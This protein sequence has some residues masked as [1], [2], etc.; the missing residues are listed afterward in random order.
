MQNCRTFLDLYYHIKEFGTMVSP[1]GCKCL[2]LTN[3]CVT[4]NSLYPVSSFEARK[5]NLD[6]AKKETLWYLRGDRF[7]TSICQE[8]GAWN[9]LVQPDGGINSN[10]GQDIFQGPKLFDWVIEE[11]TR[12]KMSRRAVMPLGRADMLGADNSDHR[13][14]MFISYLIRDN[15]LIQSVHMRSNDAIFGLTNDVFFFGLLHQMVLVCL[16]EVYP[17]LELGEYHHIVDSIHVYER[18]FSMLDRLLSENDEG[19][20]DLAIPTFKSK[21]EVDWLRGDR[22]TS[23]DSEMCNWLVEV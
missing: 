5:F 1:R 10:Y 11:L 16:Q 7:D 13:C 9:T 18:H 6:Y 8:A 12:D 15:R 17:D 23:I 4:F 19:W 22:S 2:E 3:A 21:A 20:Y 14:T